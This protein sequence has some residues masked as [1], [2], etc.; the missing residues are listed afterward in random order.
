[1]TTETWR[2]SRLHQAERN[3]EVV[4]LTGPN[5]IATPGSD[6]LSSGEFAHLERLFTKATEAVKTARAAERAAFQALHEARCNAE[7]GPAPSGGMWRCTLQDDHL[8]DCS[9]VF[10][11]GEA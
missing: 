8:G 10:S 9:N 3:G 5:S 2:G 7:F 6:A 1:M 4:K 11:R